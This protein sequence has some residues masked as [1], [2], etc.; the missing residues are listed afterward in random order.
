[1]YVNLRKHRFL[2]HSCRTHQATVNRVKVHAKFTKP[3][4]LEEKRKVGFLPECVHEFFRAFDQLK[5][6]AR[7]QE[8][9]F[10]D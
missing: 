7:L 6:R 8:V 9:T 1:L 4:H 2:R 3:C 10:V 5:L